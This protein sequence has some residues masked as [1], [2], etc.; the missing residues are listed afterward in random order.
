MTAWA[1]KVKFTLAAGTGLF[2]DGYINLTISLDMS[3]FFLSAV[4][5]TPTEPAND[6]L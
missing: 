4:L 2:T 5:P 1:E 3:P 6:Q